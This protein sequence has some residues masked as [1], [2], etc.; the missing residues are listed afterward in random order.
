MRFEPVVHGDDGGDDAWA[1]SSR[2]DD[3]AGC[4]RRRSFQ[5]VVLE[6]ERFDL[7]HGGVPETEGVVEG[8]PPPT[9]GA[10][11]FEEWGH[12]AGEVVPGVDFGDVDVGV[13]EDV[14]AV[15]EEDGVDVV[16]EAEDVAARGPCGEGG[17]VEFVEEV[18]G[19]DAVG[20]VDEADVGE[21]A[22]EN[23]DD[24]GIFDF[25]DVGDG[26]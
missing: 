13:F 12:D 8:L 3:E 14:G 19:F 7:V 4:F 17:G 5:A 20:E 26:S 15:G 25:D 24:E 22:G 1:F 10:G 18:G 11:L 2:V 23:A 21:R 16:G 9:V 6:D